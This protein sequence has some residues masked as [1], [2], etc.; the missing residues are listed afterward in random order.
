MADQDSAMQMLDDD[1]VDPSLNGLMHDPALTENKN[2]SSIITHIRDDGAARLRHK[3]TARVANRK[4]QQHI[5]NVAA[6]QNHRLRQQTPSKP[7]QKRNIHPALQSY[8]SIHEDKPVVQTA[9][10]NKSQREQGRWQ[11]F[12]LSLAIAVT[13]VMGFNLYQLNDQAIDMRA[14]LESYE[15]QIDKLSSTQKKS[16][17]TLI[18]VSRMNKELIGLKQE[19]GV[20]ENGLASTRDEMTAIRAVKEEVKEVKGA[21]AVKTTPGRLTGGGWVVNLASLSSEQKA[22]AGAAVLEKSGI[23]AD[24]IPAIVNGTM[25]YRLSVKGFSSR[26]DAMQFVNKARQQYG[27][28]GGWVWQG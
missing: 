9:V 1:I 4:Q 10:E 3:K 8:R 18:N 12:L 22:R 6:K 21:K 24:V 16:S 17:D 7:E 15:A 13:A 20:L 25:L 19:V 26:A 28:D 5:K 2:L 27:F 14:T 23:Q 11:P